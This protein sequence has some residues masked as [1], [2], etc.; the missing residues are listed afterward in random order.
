MSCQ[1]L[2]QKIKRQKEIIESLKITFDLDIEELERRLGIANATIYKMQN[3]IEML[4]RQL[5]QQD[6]AIERKDKQF[7]GLRMA[8][9]D[10]VINNGK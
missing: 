8:Y 9:A 3:H 1:N 7:L 10:E 6:K 5:D 2:K 4:N